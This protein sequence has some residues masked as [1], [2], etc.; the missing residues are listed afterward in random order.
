MRDTYFDVTDPINIKIWELGTELAAAWEWHVSW[1]A[2]GQ[3]TFI[4]YRTGDSLYM[5]RTITDSLHYFGGEIWRKGWVPD[6]GQSMNLINS[7][8]GTIQTATTNNTDTIVVNVDFAP[9][10]QDSVIVW[11][12]DTVVSNSII[13]S[14]TQQQFYDLLTQPQF[15]LDTNYFHTLGDSAIMIYPST[16]LD[17]GNTILVEY[18][19]KHPG[20][21]EIRDSMMAADPSIEIGFCVNFRKHLLGRPSFDAR[22][23]QS[24]PR[25]LVEHPYNDN[26]DPALSNGFYSEIIYLAEKKAREGFRED[27]LELDSI[28]DAMGIP[29]PI[30]IGLTEWNIRLCG[31]NNCSLAYNG[32]L[33]GLYVA[34]FFTQFYEA[35]RNESI[36]LRVCNHFATVA[37][38]FNLI[39]L[40]HYDGLISGVSTTAQSEAIR[41]TNNAIGENLIP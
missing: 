7:N 3:H 10:Q 30:G 19:T 33:G 27:Q 23:V 14:L 40:F 32:I 28:V 15:L 18:K 11:A 39:H 13:N 9:I 25:F 26:T 24:P 4:Y 17:S 38:G 41:I 37:Q 35:Q 29:N 34:N 22:L 1:V 21:F 2:G 36:D 16:P 20:A 31:N 6:V 12:V 5:P 8:L